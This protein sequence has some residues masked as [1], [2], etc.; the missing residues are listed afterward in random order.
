MTVGVKTLVECVNT[1]ASTVSEPLKILQLSSVSKDFEEGFVYSVANVGSLP[2]AACNMGRL[3]YVEDKCSYRFSDGV[4]WSN[5]FTTE[6]RNFEAWA[7]GNGANGRLGNNATTDRCSPVSVVGGFTDWCQVSAGGSHSLAVQ[8]NGTAWAWG[9]G[10][11]GRLGNNATTD[12]CSPVSVVGGFTDWCQVSAGTSHSLGVRSNGTAWAWGF[13]DSG[14]LG[15]N[16]TTGRTSPVLVVG[17]FTN[18][19]QVSAA[20]VHSLGVRSN[21][22]AWAWGSNL[23]GRLGD[24]TVTS[25][26]SPVSVV[27]GFTDWCQVSAG[28]EHSIGLR[29]NGTVWAWGLNS[30]GQLGNNSTTNTS[31]PVSV[32]GGFTDWCQVSANSCHN[33]GVRSNGTA[34]G[35]GSGA[36]GRLGNNTTT[37]TSSPVSV[38]GGFTDWCQVNAGFAHSIGLRSNGTAWAWGSN[39]CGRLG[40]GT[41][42]QRLSPILVAGG[43]TDW[44]Q[45]SAGD[46][47][48]LAVRSTKG[49]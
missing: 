8:Q 34:W 16:T 36:N 24:G 11:N 7:W 29:S 18:W 9:G 42:T 40:D 5:D 17:G 28:S 14:R 12:R 19:I 23:C 6:A 46:A 22:T 43:F 27:G 45:A 2:S 4:V 1:S 26:L 3:I 44:C 21:G 15:D 38:V 10:A 37:N 25:R 39:V 49:F 47:H 35:W 13:N 31:S 41:V 32:V 33:L 30:S 20:F 48:S